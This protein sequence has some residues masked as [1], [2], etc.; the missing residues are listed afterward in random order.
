MGKGRVKLLLCKGGFDVRH[1]G[2]GDGEGVVGVL[3]DELHGAGI[4]NHLL[5]LGKVDEEG[6]C[7]YSGKPSHRR[8][9]FARAY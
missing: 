8:V 9:I 7:V 6:R 4:G 1:V 5:H 3:D 2:A